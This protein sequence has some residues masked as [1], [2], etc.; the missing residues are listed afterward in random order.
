MHIITTIMKTMIYSAHA[1]LFPRFT[2]QL[3]SLFRLLTISLLSSLLKYILP[4]IHPSSLSPDF[5]KILHA[6]LGG[7]N[8]NVKALPA[9]LHTGLHAF[10]VYLHR[11]KEL[12]PQ[13]APNFPLRFTRAPP[14]F[15]Q[16]SS[17]A[18]ALLPEA[19]PPML[20]ALLPSILPMHS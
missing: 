19:S 6:A 10:L 7:S 15:G 9:R 14:Q 3:H 1:H 4:V 20:C 18:L 2:V 13:N 5:T 16:L 11:G 12:Q 8:R 17:V